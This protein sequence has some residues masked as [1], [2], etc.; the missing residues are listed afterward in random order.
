MC[1]MTSAY[2]TPRTVTESIMKLNYDH[3]TDSVYIDLNSRPGVDS[4]EIQE[5]AVIDVDAKG[6]IVGVD[7]Q[8][9]SEAAT[10]TS[11]DAIVQVF[12]SY[13]V[14]NGD[15]QREIRQ[16]SRSSGDSGRELVALTGIEPVFE[17]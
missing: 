1:F 10:K 17:D 9:A 5:G 7:I 2:Q 3:E 14:P 16:L 4:R 15:P 13:F 8:P 12:L 6:K 11:I